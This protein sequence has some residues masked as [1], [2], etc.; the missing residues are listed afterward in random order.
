MSKNTANCKM[1]NWVRSLLFLFQSG[2]GEKNQRNLI[3]KLD[4]HS[5]G[6]CV[7]SPVFVLEGGVD[8][9]VIMSCTRARA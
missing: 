6:R 1:K 7:L 3:S 2:G 8:A 5:L 9:L 4:V